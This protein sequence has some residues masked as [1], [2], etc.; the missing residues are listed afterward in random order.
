MRVAEVA[1]RGRGRRGGSQRRR[2]HAG[3]GS[4]AGARMP[5]GSRG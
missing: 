5:R 1:V 4:A 2:R 3:S